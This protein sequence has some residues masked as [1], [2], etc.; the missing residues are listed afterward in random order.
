[1]ATPGQKSDTAGVPLPPPLLYVAGLLAGLGLELAFPIDG[2]S[3]AIRVAGAVAGI[4]LWLVFD[5]VAMRSF[6][7]AG[8]SMIPFNPSTSL[9]TDGVY[10]V[11]RNPMYVGM[12]CFYIGLAL[13]L[14]LIW[15]LILLP[16][17]ILAVDRLIIAREEPYLE[18]LFGESYREYKRTTRRWI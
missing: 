14:S 6:R 16:V 5:G 18:R 4:G 10:R 11:T 13:A 2:P 3:T 12:A 15:A 7:A 8:T 1:M 9:V 17:V